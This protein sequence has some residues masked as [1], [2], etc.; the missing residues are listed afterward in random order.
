MD[1]KVD[2]RIFMVGL[3]LLGGIE[4]KPRSARETSYN[5]VVFV[6]DW[7]EFL[8]PILSIPKKLREAFCVIFDEDK[9]RS[10][11]FTHGEA[12]A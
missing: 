10:L 3:R 9:R 11:S 7:G 6:L 8:G 2:W 12:Q 1:D 4:C 5:S